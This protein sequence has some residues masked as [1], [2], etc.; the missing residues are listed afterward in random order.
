MKEF[1]VSEDVLKQFVD[2]VITY[3]IIRLIFEHTNSLI[4]VL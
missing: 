2:I 3:Y 4:Q 1:T